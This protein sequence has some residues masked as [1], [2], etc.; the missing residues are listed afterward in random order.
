MKRDFTHDQRV[1][2]VAF[3]P[4]R[5]WIATAGG[6]GGM[7]WD[8]ATGNE[9]LAI[10]EDV[11][12]CVAFSPDSLRIATANGDGTVKIWDSKTGKEL[13]SVP[14]HKGFVYVNSVV[15]SPDGRKLVTAGSDVGAMVW[16]A[17]TGQLLLTLRGVGHGDLALSVAF[18]SDG[19]RIAVGSSGTVHI[20]T[21]DIRELLDIAARTV[22]RELSSEECQ[23]YFRGACPAW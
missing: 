22:T 20:Y 7:I 14:A 11:I 18:S 4:N 19:R 8:A 23:R 10:G 6:G 9:L 21:T 3:S 15:F 17:V 1:S 2:S 5:R 12:D 16:D 13:L